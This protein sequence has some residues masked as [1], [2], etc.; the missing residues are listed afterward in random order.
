MEGIK[1]TEHEKQIKK[2]SIFREIY[3]EI[4]MNE[5]S[6]GQKENKKERI[7]YVTN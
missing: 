1:V 7:N 3:R 5:K 4:F 2:E 6:E